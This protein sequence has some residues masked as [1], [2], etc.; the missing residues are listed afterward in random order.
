MEFYG[1]SFLFLGLLIL[2]WPK[3]N[4]AYSFARF[5]WLLGA[6]GIAH[7]T[8]EGMELW[9]EMPGAASA[10][11]IIEPVLL[12]ASYLFL[13]EFGRRLTLCSLNPGTSSSIPRRML[14]PWLYILALGAI[15][16]GS[17]VSDQPLQDLM[18]LSRYFAGFTG[19]AL[20]GVGFYRYWRYHVDAQLVDSEHK[21]TRF[22]FYALAF[23]FAAYGVFGS[24]IVPRAA[25][26][27]ASWINYE[28][29]R[30]IFH[31]PVQLAKALCAAVT[32]ISMIYI[33]R[34][35]DIESRARLV[36]AHAKNELLLRTA[37]DG[38]HVLDAEGNVVEANDAFCQM[39]GYTREEVLRMH[40]SQWDANFSAEELRQ[41]MPLFLE[42][43]VVFE[44]RH[45]RR[46][47]K[48]IDVEISTAGVRVADQSLL[49]CA[50]RDISDRKHAE[51][52][53]RLVAQVFD[54]AAEG[55]MITDEH[56]KIL[57]VND[58]FCAVTGYTRGDVIG[59][60]PAILHSGKHTPDFY[61][62]MWE[63]LQRSGWW[64]GEVWNRRKNGEPHLE[65]L[66]INAVRNDEGK[67]INCIGMFSDIA[68][69]KES[70]QRMEFLATHD[71]LTGLP[72][73]A[74]FNDHLKLALAR[75]ARTGTHQALLFVDLDNFKMINDTLGHE[76]GD[77]LLKQAADRLRACVRGMDTVARLGGDEFVALLEIGD[78]DE[79]DASAR[80]IL[81]AFAPSFLLKAQECFIT[82]SIG[83]SL[84]P[85]DAPEAALLMRHADTAMYRA[86]ERGKNAYMFF[87]ADM[88]EHLSIRMFI[89]NALRL[90]IPN[91]ELFLEYQPLIDLGSNALVGVE[92]LLRW[93]H[94][95]KTI[96]PNDFIRIAEESG[97][98][99]D[100][101]EW[102]MGEVC[103]QIRDW[104]Q[105]GLPPFWVSLNLSA[106]HFR[107]PDLF[108]RLTG[109]VALAGIPPR[110]LCLEIT[111]GALMDMEN[112]SRILH[113]LHDAGF[114]MSVDDFGTGFS[115][116]SYL[117]RY[118][119]HELKIDRSFVSGLAGNPDDRAI[120]TAIIA[121][122]HELGLQTVA[123]GVESV[124]Q[125]EALNVLG[126]D[127]VQG[128]L[129]SK[130]LAAPL[131]TDWVLD[132]NG[133]NP[134][135]LAQQR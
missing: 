60:T 27:P 19:A 41:R 63:D 7:G 123:E 31:F 6:F 62:R 56:Q 9:D 73:R 134:A 36:A 18:I 66:S 16:Y 107:R 129:Y 102:V 128:Y 118:P 77:A 89:E 8:F 21:R 33:L 115:S 83:I 67:I 46:D 92:A 59:N 94:Q 65:W 51:E 23:S 122:A 87:T 109:V 104:D 34:I 110:R 70:R 108:P 12:L 37:G 93:R 113:Q 81:E 49:Y 95:G 29:F 26:F 48:V 117:K 125:H 119:L 75:S 116:L 74:M 99:V 127:I 10:L 98:I 121:M 40:V 130:P 90:A 5:L 43:R 4:S 84:F 88:A 1:L 64:Q 112:S 35:F 124:V 61:K 44:T 120:T 52:Q 76:E 97:L 24:L 15:L 14:A 69:I 114:R 135:R 13:F 38:I 82:T 126:C 57:T 79:A 105:A 32:A 55:V 68:V 25:W 111:E 30:E 54:R 106:R 3:Q 58:A 96:P 103:R 20:T 42:K 50:S 28:S 22:A 80:R 100:I 11:S 72:N 133:K 53:L 78:R 101:E 45:R 71:A 86:K 132:R 2:V 131:L 47:G 85:E 91:G 39:L 17:A